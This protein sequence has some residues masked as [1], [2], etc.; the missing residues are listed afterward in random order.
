MA[1]DTPSNGFSPPPVAVNGLMSLRRHVATWNFRAMREDELNLTRGDILLV[2]EKFDDGWTRGIRMS[3]LEV[4]YFPKDFVTE[5]TSPVY[6]LKDI[7]LPTEHYVSDPTFAEYDS[8][9]RSKVALEICTTE[10]SYFRKLNL[11]EEKFAVPLS[12]NGIIAAEECNA[13]FRHIQVLLR[14]SHCLLVHLQS[15]MEGWDERHTLMGDIF[16]DLGHHMKVFISYATH[17]TIAAQLILK[18]NKQEKFRTWLEAT[19]AECEWTLNSL[20]IEPIQRIPRYELLLKDL[21]KYT[22][23]DHPDHGLLREALTFVQKIARDCND[24]VKK[25]ENEL[26]L[27]SIAKR[28][29]NDDVNIIVSK[30]QT[31][32]KARPESGGRSRLRSF[33]SRRFKKPPGSVSNLPTDTS[34]SFRDFFEAEHRREF[35]R[36]GVLLKTKSDFSDPSERYLFLCSDILLVAQPNSRSHKTFRLKERALLRHVWVTDTLTTNERG[37]PQRGFILG[38]P[39]KVYH[40]LAPS[41]EEKGA[42][43]ADLHSHIFAQKRLFH[44]VLSHL[45]IPDEKFFFA[46]ANAKVQYV[47]VL[48]D[49]LSFRAGDGVSVLGFKA[50]GERWQ[51]GLYTTQ[52]AFDPSPEWYFGSHNGSF[53]WFPAQCLVGADSRPLEPP[54]DELKPAAMSVVLGLKQRMRELTGR[55]VPPLTEYERAVKVCLGEGNF[56]ILRIPSHVRVDDIVRKYFRARPDRSLQWA[57]IEQ[58]VDETVQRLLGADEDPSL[59]VDFWGKSKDQMKFVLKQSLNNHASSHLSVVS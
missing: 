46:L 7:S 51:A 23:E 58:S 50:G 45:S 30:C 18:L 40:F 31:T 44:K 56:K 37:I 29:P 4:G 26:K 35:V 25:A 13:I 21:L 28:F 57:L 10:E 33:G 14:L 8:C 17:H 20:L 9:K 53:G 36:E 41:S 19:K 55:E 27:F 43:F 34:L 52:E 15:R 59:V 5:D 47:G 42:W 22:N 38:T 3:D 54:Q 1:K 6:T 49:E 24:S 11:L 2:A 48:N 39:L 12:Q 32:I 16:L